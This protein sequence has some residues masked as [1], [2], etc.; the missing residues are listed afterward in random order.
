MVLL[1]S[2]E[3]M[4]KFA[5]RSK[6]FNFLAENEKA[7]NQKFNEVLEE[8]LKGELNTNKTIAYVKME[9]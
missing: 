9:L 6:E 2:A 4:Y 7:S 3:L 8:A 5:P 1:S